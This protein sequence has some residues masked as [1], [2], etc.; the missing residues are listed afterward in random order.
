MLKDTFSLARELAG[1]AR[2]API[3]PRS[4]SSCKTDEALQPEDRR[5][6]T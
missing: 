5:K 4:E 1:A 2:G 3:P 6:A